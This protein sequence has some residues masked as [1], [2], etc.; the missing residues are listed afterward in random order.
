MDTMKWN[1]MRT[2]QSVIAEDDVTSNVTKQF[3]LD[4]LFL[5]L[6]PVRLM[7]VDIKGALSISMCTSV[8]S[9]LVPTGTFINH[10][11]AQTV[12]SAGV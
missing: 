4:L 3:F 5:P 6:G 10:E 8:V 7:S 1:Y 12:Y 2:E 9:G 11:T